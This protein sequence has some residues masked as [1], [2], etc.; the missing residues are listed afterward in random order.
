MGVIFD[1][2]GND[3]KVLVESW[4]VDDIEELGLLGRG[5]GL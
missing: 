2:V 4:W 3:V 5:E 1:E